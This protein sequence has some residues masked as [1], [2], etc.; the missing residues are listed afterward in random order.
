MSHTGGRWEDVACDL[1]AQLAAPTGEQRRVASALS[2]L[3]PPDVPSGVAS[4]ILRAALSTALLEDL[5]LADDIPQVLWD[6]E[7]ELSVRRTTKLITGTRVELSAWFAA[8]YVL[9]TVRGLREVRPEV[10]DVV[11][12]VSWG[13]GERRVISSIASNGRVYMR[14][15]PPLSAWPNSLTIVSRLSDENH[16]ELVARVDAELRNRRRLRPTSAANFDALEP[17]QVQSRIPSAEAIRALEDLLESGERR[18]APF[19]RLLDRYPELLACAVVGGW[20]TFV[21][22]QKRLGSEYVPD[23]LVLGLNSAG[24]QWVAVEI[25]GAS[26]KILRNDGRLAEQVRHAVGQ[27]TD[28]REWLL[29][30]VAYAQMELGLHGLTVNSPGLVIIGRDSPNPA[31]QPARANLAEREGI[32]VHSWDWLLR[33]ARSL[34][35]SPFHVS[36]FAATSLNSQAGWEAVTLP[37]DLQDDYN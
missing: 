7:D 21:I 23:F 29:S 26:H 30:N 16:L 35:V 20:Q 3:L 18:E 2:V 4:V 9:K 11:T 19:Q 13:K 12:S 37:P 22:S 25:E 34:A 32:A 17:Y 6:I 1:E 33:H 10:G 5:P 8:R 27:I 36:A 24:P 31:R 14:H 28:W 15:H